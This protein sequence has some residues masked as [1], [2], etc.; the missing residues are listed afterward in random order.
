MTFRTA[1]DV[2]LAPLTIA[3]VRYATVALAPVRT[4]LPPETTGLLSLTFELIGASATFAA[5]PDT[6]R[7][8]LSGAREIVAAL[9]DAALLYTTRTFVEAGG[10]GTWKRVDPL[11]SAVG[12]ADADALLDPPRDATLAPFHLLTEYAVFPE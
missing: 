8:H 3:S 5:V 9:A 1:Y 12:L 4:T 6:V 10:S 2:T 7:L 11:L